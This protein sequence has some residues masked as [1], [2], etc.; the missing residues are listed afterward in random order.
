[1]A[2]EFN[3]KEGI[4]K[5]LKTALQ[6][7][8]FISAVFSMLSGEKGAEKDVEYGLKSA[9]QENTLNEMV[10]VHRLY[11]HG[12]NENAI[13]NLTSVPKELT[14]RLLD[15]RKKSTKF[16]REVLVRTLKK[17]GMFKRFVYIIKS[18]C[19]AGYPIDDVVA[20][21][22][23]IKFITALV[24]TATEI[25]KEDEE[26]EVAINEAV[27][28]EKIRRA[29]RHGSRSRS[30]LSEEFED[31]YGGRMPVNVYTGRFQPFHLGHLSNLEEAAKRGLRTVICPVKPGKTVKSQAN[32]YFDES[33]QKEIFARLKAEYGD[34]IAGIIPIDSPAP[35]NWVEAIRNTKCDGKLM[36]PITW[37]TGEDQKPAYENMIKRYGPD[38]G[39]VDNFEVIGLPKNVNA[40]GGGSMDNKQDI[41]GREVRK[42]LI[43]NDIE[44]FKR[45]MPKCLWDM[46]PE[47]REIMQQYAQPAITESEA[48]AKYKKYLNEAIEKLVKG[49]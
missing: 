39:L 16:Q 10:S 43:N 23:A 8:S 24:E 40:G 34:L 17:P 29:F 32:H 25:A 13:I 7:D 9:A 28:L 41:E 33:I 42:C 35:Q 36:E 45:Q 1:M 46:Y 30:V 20:T 22:M 21:P 2:E 11:K 14:E 12:L 49:E 47:M 5:S 48:Y 31:K 37:T 18:L 3:I 6:S 4:V 38:L 27:V 26:T 44:G 15:I 19:T